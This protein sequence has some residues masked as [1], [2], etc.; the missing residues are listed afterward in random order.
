M[1]YRWRDAHGVLQI[2]E[3]PPKGRKYQRV[4]REPYGGI[5]VHGDRSSDLP[6]ASA[7]AD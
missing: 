5:E 4:D 2:T 7:E 1:L 6:D 3:Q